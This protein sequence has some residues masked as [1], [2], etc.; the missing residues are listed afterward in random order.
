MGGAAGSLGGAAAS[1]GQCGRMRT[2]SGGGGRVLQREGK[3][4]FFR[5]SCDL[6][7]LQWSWNKY[8]LLYHVESIS[9]DW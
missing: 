5:L 4:R 2:T 1:D 8:A 3:R 7:T 9:A 6:T